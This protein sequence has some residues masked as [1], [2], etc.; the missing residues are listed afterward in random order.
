MRLLPSP[1][2]LRKVRGPGEA[3]SPL[4]LPL[5]WQV[6]NSSDLAR[7]D[8]RLT[9]AWSIP[10]VPHLGSGWSFHPRRFHS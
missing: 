3:E 5:L 2:V 9:G 8:S 4:Q 10:P 6:S 7:A 1:T